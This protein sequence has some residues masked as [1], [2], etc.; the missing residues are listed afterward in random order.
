LI[1]KSTVTSP[2]GQTGC[3]FFQVPLFLSS[4]GWLADESFRSSGIGSVTQ[5]CN[6]ASCV[7]NLTVTSQ[8]VR[9]DPCTKLL[10]IVGDVG[11]PHD[12][13]ASEIAVVY[14][15]NSRSPEG[16]RPSVVP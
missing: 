14:G 16:R 6:R 2:A 12:V 5:R 13:P 11:T 15:S 9:R 3:C 7:R 4:I 10:A 8:D 1:E